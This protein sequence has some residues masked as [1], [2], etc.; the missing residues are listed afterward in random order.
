MHVSRMSPRKGMTDATMT[1]DTATGNTTGADL[2]ARRTISTN[3]ATEVRD[4][5]QK[6][7]RRVSRL[8]KPEVAVPAEKSPNGPRA[9]VI[10]IDVRGPHDQ[11]LPADAAQR[12]EERRVGKECRSRWSPYH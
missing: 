5:G 8:P 9:R 7:P 12:S 4:S 3:R 11:V 10:V 6:Y 1:N 2:H